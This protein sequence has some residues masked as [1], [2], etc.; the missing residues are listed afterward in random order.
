MLRRFV[1]QEQH[2]KWD[3][4]FKENY[5]NFMG[6]LFKDGYAIELPEGDI[7]GK[8]GKTWYQAHFSMNTSGKIWVVFDCTAK[9]HKMNLN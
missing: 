5:F 3:Q 6:K 2:F 4:K 1:K 9:Y 7:N 8:S